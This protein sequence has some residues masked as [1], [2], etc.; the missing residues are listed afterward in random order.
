MGYITKICLYNFDP[1]KPHFNIEKLGFTGIQ[2]I[3]LISSQKHTLLVLVRTVSPR[4]AN[5]LCFAQ[6]IENYQSFLSENFQ[7]LEGKCSIYLNRRVFRY[8]QHSVVFFFFFFFFFFSYLYV[9]ACV[10]F[11]ESY[12]FF[13]VSFHSRITAQAMSVGDFNVL[14]DPFLQYSGSKGQ[15]RILFPLQTQLLTGP[16]LLLSSCMAVFASG[17]KGNRQDQHLSV[18]HQGRLMIITK[19]RSCFSSK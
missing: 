1:L 14:P 3:F 17:L 6:K 12:T 19:S 10:V 16:V 7:F 13:L 5:N 4:R 9:G 8:I 11:S 18:R 2:I 15:E